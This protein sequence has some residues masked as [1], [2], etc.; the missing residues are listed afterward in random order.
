MLKRILDVVLAGLGLLFTAPLWLAI[1]LLV[2]LTSKG[3]V[4]F[5]Q[6][7]AGLRGQCFTLLK[8]RTMIDT[9]DS[10]GHLLPDGH[11]LTRFGRFLRST[12][13]DELPELINVLK[14]DMSL[15]GPR[16]LLPQY[17]GRYTPQQSRR[18]EVKP[19]ITGW[20][21]INGRNAL[22]WEQKF[23]LDVW[24]VEHRSV[25]LD[26]KIIFLTAWKT[27]KREGINQPGRATADE[28]MGSLQ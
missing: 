1:A 11:R 17:L 18:H 4:F 27:L 10:K 6:Q 19:G 13:L 8:F 22:T 23:A 7:R 21:Q 26:A 24:Y 12:S 16:P 3:P 28:F 15:V 9:K 2:K 20:A 5:R 14:G 25:F